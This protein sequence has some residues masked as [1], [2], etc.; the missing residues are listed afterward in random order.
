MSTLSRFS[1]FTSAILFT[2][3]ASAPVAAF[4]GGGHGGGVVAATAVAGMS[5]VAEVSMAAACVPVA[6]RA[7]R[8]PVSIARRGDASPGREP[9]RHVQQREPH[10][11]WLAQ[12]LHGLSLGLGSRLLERPL[13]RRFRL[14]A[15]W[16]RFGYPGYGGLGYG[17]LGYGG[18][19]YGGLGY[20]GLA[21]TAGSVM[22]GSVTA[23][24]AGTAGTAA[25]WVL[26]WVWAW[27]GG[28]PPG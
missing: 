25:V 3:S 20:G 19:G 23:G 7:M 26:A 27:A 1:T 9:S 17:G 12:Q 11:F 5:V 2:L 14:A 24:S 16:Q 13:S 10:G 15:L 18:L 28:F 8:H 4:H 6:F 21:G 22:A